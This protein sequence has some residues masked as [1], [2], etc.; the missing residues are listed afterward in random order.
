MFDFGNKIT[1]YAHFTLEIVQSPPCTSLITNGRCQ[2][3]LG[4]LKVILLILKNIP[5][6][7]TIFPTIPVSISLWL[8]TIT[9]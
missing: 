3:L 5:L 6:F 9:L 1:S 2:N 4:Y 7:A 8:L